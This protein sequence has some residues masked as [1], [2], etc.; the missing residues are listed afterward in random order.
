MAEQYPKVAVVIL[1]WNGRDYLERFLPAVCATDYPNLDIYIV[2]NASTDDSVQYVR[3]SFPKVSVIEHQANQGFAGGYNTGLR[4]VEA[5]YYVLL[6]QDVSVEES[7]IRP[8]IT[9]MESR[10]EIGACQ[11]KIRSYAQPEYF[12]YAGAAGGWIDRWGYPFCRGRLFDTL[13]K[14][15]GQ[16]DEARP[17]FWASGAALF[18]RAR[19]YREAGGLDPYFFAHM[20]EIDLC[21]R[22]QRL[23]HQVWCCPQSVV[24]HV[25]GGS[26]PR[27]NPRKT[28]LNYRNNLLMLHKNLR[29]MERFCTLFVRFSLDGVAAIKC[30]LDG[31]P[32]D[33][34]AIL[35]SHAAYYRWWLTGAWKRGM[36]K[37]MPAP[38]LRSSRLQGVY[39][40]SLV[41]RYFIGKARKFSSLE[42]PAK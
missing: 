35:K 12:E 25:G 30:L 3:G 1:N 26:L 17:V 29:G 31:N 21:W 36:G 16:Y 9:L 22:L 8:V 4:Q 42:F 18:I 19:L 10:R 13:E 41:W 23:G 28:F 2:D 7:W 15:E 40:Y 33:L 32:R 14:D 38:P 11:P 5:D 24:Y 34:F 20:E 37:P 27:G 6:N 39:P